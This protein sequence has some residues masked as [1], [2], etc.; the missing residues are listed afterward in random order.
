MYIVDLLYFWV[1]FKYLLNKLPL[2][3]ASDKVRDIHHTEYAYGTYQSGGPEIRCYSSAGC[4]D[5][6][7]REE[8]RQGFQRKH[9]YQHK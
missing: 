8:K 2:G 4:H 5:N 9:S 1:L 3:K 7:H 6:K